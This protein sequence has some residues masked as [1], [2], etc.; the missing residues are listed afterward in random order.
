MNALGMFELPG[1][2]W[3]VAVLF[4]MVVHRWGGGPDTL[5]CRALVRIHQELWLFAPVGL[6][7]LTYGDWAERNWFGMFFSLFN[8]ALWWMLRN[9]PDDNIWKRRGKRALDRVRAV[10]GRLVVS[11]A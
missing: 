8:F 10:A 1:R 7:A 11:P 4:A 9:W 3:L 5:F 6:L 2:M